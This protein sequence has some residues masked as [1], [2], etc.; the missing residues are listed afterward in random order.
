MVVNSPEGP[1]EALVSTETG[2]KGQVLKK[3]MILAYITEESILPCL[4]IM[5]LRENLLFPKDLCKPGVHK[6][7][8]TQTRPRWG[9][10]L[11]FA[12]LSL[13]KPR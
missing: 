4:I 2:C 5:N 3:A 6:P 10:D 9:C 8:M 13:S 11:L 1:R 12:C 7:L